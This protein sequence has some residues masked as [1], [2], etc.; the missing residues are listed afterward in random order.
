MLRSGARKP[1][2]GPPCRIWAEW[3]GRP[4][5]AAWVATPTWEA[6]TEAC[7]ARRP[8]SNH[9]H[10]TSLPKSPPRANRRGRQIMA[11]N[12][13]E[14]LLSLGVG[15]LVAIALLQVS[16]NYVSGMFAERQ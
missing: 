7:L 14:R 3:V 8:T 6:G 9:N 15:G 5:R 1:R 11:L 2:S 12:R 10:R 4:G 16:Y 13:R